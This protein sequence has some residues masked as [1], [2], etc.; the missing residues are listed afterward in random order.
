MPSYAYFQKKYIPL[1]NAK[2]GIM[3]NFAHYGT[4]VFE[5]IRG[6]WNKRRQ[7]ALPLP[8]KRT[9]RKVDE[10]LPRLEH[11]AA[12]HRRRPL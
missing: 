1:A 4:G 5:G 6:N 9:L 2:M 10:R 11:Q 7:P 3:T 12:L 8:V